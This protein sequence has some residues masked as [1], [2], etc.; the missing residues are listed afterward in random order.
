MTGLHTKLGWPIWQVRTIIEVTVLAI[1]W[2]L[3]GNVGV[4][5]VAFALLIGPIANV[6]LPL[7][8]VP[9]PVAAT[10]APEPGYAGS[11]VVE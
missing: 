9:E 1:G 6:T 3:G 11:P 7:L 10:T 2:V 5:T 8:R 4:G